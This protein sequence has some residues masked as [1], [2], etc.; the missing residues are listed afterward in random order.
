[1]VMLH[2]VQL[3]LVWVFMTLLSYDGPPFV[4]LADLLWLVGISYYLYITFLGYSTLPFLRNTVYL[5]YAFLPLT[6]LV[7]I[8]IPLQL[9]WTVLW[10]SFFMSL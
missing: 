9:N 3:V 10:T 6:V 2:G 4:I 5:L 8:S 7:L 1:M